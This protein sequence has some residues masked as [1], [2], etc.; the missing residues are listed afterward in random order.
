MKEKNDKKHCKDLEHNARGHN[1]N[2]NVIKKSKPY[3]TSKV[4]EGKEML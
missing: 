4:V 1:A 3:P 2:K